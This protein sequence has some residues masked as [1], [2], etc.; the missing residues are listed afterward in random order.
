VQDFVIHYRQ[1]ARKQTTRQTTRHIARQ[2]TRRLPGDVRHGSITPL[3]VAAISLL[4]FGG[5]GF[6]W[7]YNS[8]SDSKSISPILAKVT[9][10]EF[11]SQVLDQGELQSSENVDVRCGVRAR[12]GEIKVIS[13]APEGSQVVEGDFLVQLDS[14]AFE[15]ELD[16][17]KITLANAETTK[18]QAEATLA[19]AKAALNEYVK[20]VFVEAQKVIEN[21]IYDAQSLITTAQQELKQAQAVFEHSKKLHAK[22]FITRQTLEADAFAV[23]RAE[24]G[25]RKGNNSLELAEQKMDVLKN[26]SFE[27]STIQ[28]QS[29]IR[30]AEVKL[31][32]EMDN[33]L[34][35]TSKLAEIKSNIA[36]CTLRVPPGVEGQVVYAKE[37]R[38]GDDWVLEE[39]GIVRE[40]QVLIRLPNPAKMEIKAL[41][42]EQSITQ[43]E[44]DM[45]V[46]IKV[47]ALNS[48]S[49]KGIVTKVNQY[50]ESGGWMSSSVRKYAVFVR[51]LNPPPTLRPGMNA[52][53]SIQTRYVPDALLAP[54]QTVYGLQE[55]KFCL[56]KAGEDQ[57]QTLEVTTGGDN[58]QLVMFESGVTEGMELVMNPAAYKEYMDLPE[59]KLDSKIELPENE[60]IADG[61][62]MVGAADDAPQ[63]KTQTDSPAIGSTSEE[64][65]AKREPRRPRQKPE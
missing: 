9:R 11:V 13:I 25:V 48:I 7:F 32:S 57:W 52:S 40:G 58:A 2:I 27:K 54:L 42:N 21:E 20:G 16:Q 45:P 63:S 5:L 34:V 30:A 49:L 19:S 50:A 41:I 4:I 29:D 56:A 26:I 60:A 22:A 6:A 53:V 39:G 36:K 15:V 65:P 33:F 38:R 31:A 64:Q 28:F 35:E 17:Q 8:D 3:I 61:G 18:I 24:I 55:K 1:I 10:G 51:V 12:N 43:I 23:K 14:A 47:D 44:P 46:L 62:P 59:L 37:S